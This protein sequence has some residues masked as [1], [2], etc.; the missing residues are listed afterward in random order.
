ME[1]KPII[2]DDVKEMDPKIFGE[3]LIGLRETIGAKG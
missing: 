1:F 2:G 3:G